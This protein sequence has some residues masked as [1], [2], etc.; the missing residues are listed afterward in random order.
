L[1]RPVDR[2]WSLV[3]FIYAIHFA[4]HSNP[5]FTAKLGSISLPSMADITNPRTMLIAVLATAWG[6]RLTFNFWRKGGYSGGL[7][8]GEEDYRWVEMKKVRVI[9]G[10]K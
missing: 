5:L 1:T 3:P 7:F 9:F 10:L 6:L 2:Q 4:L 8:R